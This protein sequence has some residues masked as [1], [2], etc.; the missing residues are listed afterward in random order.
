MDGSDDGE[1]EDFYDR[2]KNET[3]IDVSD[4]AQREL[5]LLRTLMV[6]ESLVYGSA[7]AIR[8]VSDIF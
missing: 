2:V 7:A 6:Q 1:E 5:E 4:D 8:K 3:S